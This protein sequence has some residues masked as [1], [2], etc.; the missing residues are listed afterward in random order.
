MHLLYHMLHGPGVAWNLVPAPQSINVGVVHSKVETPLETA[1][2]AGATFNFT[3]EAHYP[4][5]GPLINFP[6]GVTFEWTPRR[7]PAG[8][9]LPSAPGLI[10]ITPPTLTGAVASSVIFEL[11]TARL[12]GTGIWLDF[13]R[14]IVLADESD[15]FSS[16]TNFKKRV[17]DMLQGHYSP[18][19][20]YRDYQ[21]QLL[22]LQSDLMLGNK[23]LAGAN[24][25]W[26]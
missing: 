3:A 21:A 13:A 15:P 14:A 12:A 10:P 25:T 7:R 6:T 18:P 26:P 19:R 23:S 4:K 2:K 8:V 11:R 24:L 17:D 1:V 5:S 22:V 9:S 16:A 20:R